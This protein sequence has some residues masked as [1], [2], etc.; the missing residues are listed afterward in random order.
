MKLLARFTKDDPP[1]LE[2][3]NLETGELLTVLEYHERC[4]CLYRAGEQFAQRE[5]HELTEWDRTNLFTL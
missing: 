2:M 3:L 4:H 1:K 5:G